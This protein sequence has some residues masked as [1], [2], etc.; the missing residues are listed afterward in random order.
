[1]HSREII[2]IIEKIEKKYHK[3]FSFNNIN[4]WP[5]VRLSILIYFTTLRK[6]KNK[7][8][9]LIFSI[10]KWLVFNYQYFTHKDKMSGVKELF[11]GKSTSL[12]K[13]EKDNKIYDRVFDPIIKELKKK[14]FRKFYID[15]NNIQFNNIIFRIS[16]IKC[17]FNLKIL[18]DKIP[19]YLEHKLIKISHENDINIDTIVQIFRDEYFNLNKWYNF[20]NKIFIKY[21]KIKKIYVFPWYSSSIMGLILASKKFKIKTIDVQHGI[22]GKYQPMYTHWKKVP[23]N[24]YKILPD[25]FMCWNYKTKL[26]HHSSSNINLRKMHNS[27]VNNTSWINF[28]KKNFVYKTSNQQKALLFCLQPKNNKNDYLIP[29]F[30]IKYIAS[31]LS[32][33]INFIFRIHPN[34]IKSLNAIKKII[35]KIKCSNK[36]VIDKGLYNICDTL[37]KVTHTLTK[38]SSTSLEAYYFGIN[39]A[40]YGKDASENFSQYIKEKK[41]SIIG[42]NKASLHKWLNST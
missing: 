10:I 31:S 16:N 20:G 21:N 13:V 11:I 2:H 8:K 38:S 6:K 5:L 17:F 4:Y 26:Y 37:K 28:Y 29:K 33:N 3:D 39:S 34:D 27:F 25:Y 35:L 41:L 32:K 36:I 23:K 30:L 18:N 24:G 14:Y 7:Y 40:V 1:M 42:E 9:E 12:C 19:F 15:F 22:Q